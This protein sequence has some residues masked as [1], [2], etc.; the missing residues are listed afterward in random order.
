MLG[1]RSRLFP[2]AFLRKLAGHLHFFNSL[3]R[4]EVVAGSAAKV[5]RSGRS[6]PRPYE[7]TGIYDDGVD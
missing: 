1:L 5:T 6:K 3:P 7:D 2:R 4:F